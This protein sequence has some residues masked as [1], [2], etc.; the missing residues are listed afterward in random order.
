MESK[1]TMLDRL[2]NVL[3]KETVDRYV[4]NCYTLNPTSE[5][6][7]DAFLQDDL[8]KLSLFRG[9]F[10]YHESEEGFDYWEKKEKIYLRRYGDLEQASLDADTSELS[11]IYKR[12]VKKLKKN[13]K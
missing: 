10:V 7:A 12:L 3:D 13:G 1:A 8:R 6:F 9:G 2:S 4:Q 5:G 11:E